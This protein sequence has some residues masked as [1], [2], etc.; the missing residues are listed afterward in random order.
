MSRIPDFKYYLRHLVTGTWYYYYVDGAGLVTS[1]TTK[2]DLSYTPKG[3]REKTLTWERGFVYHGVF[4]TFSLP[5]DFVQDGAKI[6]RYLYVNY[7]TEGECQIYI[8]KFGNTAA[9][10]SYDPYYYGDIDFSQ[11]NDKKDFVTVSIMEGGFMAKF[12][13]KETTDIEIPITDNPDR[14]WVKMDGLEMAAIFSFTGLEQPVDNSPPTFV[15][16]GRENLP[17]LLYFQTEGYANGDHNPKGNDFLGP[18]QAMQS[19]NYAGSDVISLSIANNWFIRNV[20]NANTY[21]YRIKGS[22]TFDHNNLVAATRK[23]ILY[24]YACTPITLIPTKITIANGGTIP[25]LGTL[26]ETL[27]FDY[28]VTLGPNEAAWFFFRHTGVVGD[29]E[30]HMKTCNMTVT[31]LNKVYESFIPAIRTFTVFT[32]LMQDVN[33]ATLALSTLLETTQASKVLTCGDSLRGL[34]QGTMVTSVK[35]FYSSANS[36]FSCCMIYDRVNDRI[37]IKPIAQAYDDGTQIL[38]L[39]EVS[40]FKDYPLTEEMFAKLKVGYPDI[41][42]DGVNGK[43]EFN[44]VLNFQSGLVRVTSE[45]D[46][47][48]EYH[49]S[50]YEIENTRGNLTGKTTADAKSDNDVFWLHIEDTPSGTIPAGLPGAGED[51][52]NLQ[53]SGYTITQG[54]VSPATAFNLFLSP[55]LQIIEHGS[56][57]NSVLYPQV[58]NGGILEFKSASKTPDDKVTLE[59]SIGGSP[60]IERSNVSLSDLADPL[61]YPTVFEFDCITPTNILSVITANPYGKIRFTYNDLEYFGFL[62]SVSEEPATH[63]KQTY[64]LLCAPSTDLENLIT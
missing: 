58:N 2:R 64:K 10:P 22:I 40:N 53:R 20:S 63:A 46:W 4:Q 27:T 55:H 42:M 26:T 14:V 52:Y 48:G 30:Y 34:K 6:L 37:W 44:I 12:K 60:I 3:W 18:F 16:S 28:T 50:M 15:A 17:T 21:D 56:Y 43:D 32:A 62:L 11:Y 57:I 29:V 61:F 13:A 31:V 5:L 38:D 47:T 39:G 59:W 23:V 49:A 7:C 1:S 19:I 54:L 33:P 41:Q 8:E 51:Y 45:K 25:A 24:L 9:N 35:N 36:Q